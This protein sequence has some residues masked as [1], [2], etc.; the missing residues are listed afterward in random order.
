MIGNLF[1][2][3]PLP[4]RVSRLAVVIWIALV[5]LGATLTAHAAATLPVTPET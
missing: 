1:L 3:A 4:F 5:T 2:N